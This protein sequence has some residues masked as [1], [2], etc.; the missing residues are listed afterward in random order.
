MFVRDLDICYRY[1]PNCAITIVLSLGIQLAQIPFRRPTSPLYLT[2]KP[3]RGMGSGHAGIAV[4]AIALMY[5]VW[6]FFQSFWPK[7]FEP[8][9][10]TRN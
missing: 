10:P 4:K 2:Q 6:A 7:N 8:T 9:S 1:L 5:I 3:P